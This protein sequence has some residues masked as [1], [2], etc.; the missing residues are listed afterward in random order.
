MTKP[1]ILRFN[2]PANWM[3]LLRRAADFAAEY[4]AIRLRKD[5][6]GIRMKNGPASRYEALI[7]VA[8]AIRSHPDE[9]DL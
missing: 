5:T 8:E 7:R 6:K 4:L 3:T 2:H 9:K 1:H